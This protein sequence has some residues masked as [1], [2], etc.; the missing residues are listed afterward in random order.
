MNLNEFFNHRIGDT[1][2]LCASSFCPRGNLYVKLEK[3]NRHGSIKE[4]AAYYII[5]DLIQSGRL[6]DNIKLVES[7][8]GNLG[9]SLGLFAKEIGIDFL[10]LMDPTIP[11]EKFHLLTSHH[12]NIES[13][14]LGAHA[15]YR[16][17]RIQR[18][19]DLDAQLDWIWTKQYD[20]PSN[21][22]AH[23][24]TTGPEIWSQTKGKVDFVVCS[25]GSGGTVCGIGLFLKAV[26]PS[27]AIVAVEPLGSTIFGGESR[28]YL[29]AGAG[30]SYQPGI[31]RE[32]GNV[33]DFYSKIDDISSI[34]AC[35]SFFESEGIRVGITTGSLLKVASYLAEKFSDKVVVVIAA[36]GGEQYRSVLENDDRE[37]GISSEVELIRYVHSKM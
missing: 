8:S 11:P 3:E 24:E 20:N 21:V 36:D 14:S 35:R 25:V 29:S 18:A 6:H 12:I 23:F 1:R 27:T 4:R 17:A 30:M 34:R 32:H 37:N 33:I 28:P 15:T 22:K 31:I 9:L 26:C 19:K 13:V 16:D 7:S 2:I 10:C 5:R